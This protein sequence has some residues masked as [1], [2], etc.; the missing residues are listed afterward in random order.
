M[1]EFTAGP[2]TFEEHEGEEYGPKE[3]C[4]FAIKG[5]PLDEDLPGIQLATVVSDCVDGHEANARLIAA[6][7]DLLEALQK[8][9]FRCECFIE[10]DRVMRVTSIE[11]IN[12]ICQEAIAN[13]LA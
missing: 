2:W 9:Q 8:I 3:N 10:D 4:S 7:P 13:A 6:A 12:A 11:A 5:P 1:S